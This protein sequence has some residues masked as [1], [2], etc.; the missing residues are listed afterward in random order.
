MLRVAPE[1]GAVLLTAAGRPVGAVDQEGPS[2]ARGAS[3]IGPPMAG[4][5][6][7]PGRELVSASF[8]RSPA[9]SLCTTQSCLDGEA[10]TENKRGPLHWAGSAPGWG[11]SS[12]CLGRGYVG[13]GAVAC[14]GSIGGHLGPMGVHC[15]VVCW[16]PALWRLVKCNIFTCVFWAV[17]GWAVGPLLARLTGPH[18]LG[19][20]APAVLVDLF[21]RQLPLLL[22]EILPLPALAAV[23]RRHVLMRL[24]GRGRSCDSAWW[25]VPHLFSARWLTHH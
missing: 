22:G 6:L 13:A 3:L 23:R 20:E 9:R 24:L 1:R 15:L 4:A 7:F 14:R 12:T 25:P 17:A 2:S 16:G 21:A 18:D 10:K 5:F 11:V 8:T 19:L